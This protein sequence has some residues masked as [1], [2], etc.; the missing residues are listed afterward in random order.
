MDPKIHTEGLKTELQVK[1][2]IN[3]IQYI[4]PLKYNKNTNWNDILHVIQAQGQNP[5]RQ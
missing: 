4:S 3:S 5:T 2:G 1:Q